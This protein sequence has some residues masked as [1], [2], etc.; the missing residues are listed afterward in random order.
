[1]PGR[2]FLWLLVLIAVAS[3]YFSPSPRH[4]RHYN[5][6]PF[7]ESA[8][9]G[10]VVSIA[11]GDTLTVLDDNHSRSRIRLFGIDAPEK[12]QAFGMRSKENLS[13]KV[14]GKTVRVQVVDTDRYGRQVG[15][16][17]L[18]DR[19]INKEQVE[20]GMAWRYP[21]FD[22]QGE[23]SAP[24]A[25]ARRHARGLWSDPHPVPPWDFR[26]EHAIAAG[27]ASRHAPEER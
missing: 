16:I 21:T 11:D 2:R 8:F 22:W 3:T 26:R 5:R 14:F 13:D 23:F 19:F 10:K 17:Y 18:G 24:E 6:I 1:M 12:G 9:T 20:D 7:H 27:T 25:D 15:R 4:S